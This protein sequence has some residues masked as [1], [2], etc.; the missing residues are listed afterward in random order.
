[1]KPLSTKALGA[2]ALAMSVALSVQAEDTE[3]VFGHQLMT[4]EELQEHR[5]TLR[6]MESE[7]ARDAYRKEHHERM[8][9]RAREQGVELPD[10]PGKRG[11]GQGPRSNQGEREGPEPGHGGGLR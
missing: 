9:E 5:Q 4:A 2:V 6:G 1:M 10:K 7:A 8:R 3:K 11:K